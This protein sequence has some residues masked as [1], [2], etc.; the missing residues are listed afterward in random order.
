MF[1][2]GHLC[3]RSE[4]DVHTGQRDGED[5]PGGDFH[6]LTSRLQSLLQAFSSP[7]GSP[8][9]SSHRSIRFTG[10][11]RY[12]QIL[13]TECSITMVRPPG[14]RG[15]RGMTVGP[16]MALTLRT[17]SP[18]SCMKAPSARQVWPG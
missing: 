14:G 15:R 8:I 6:I 10:N 13:S 12:K 2:E 9:S 4:E 18:S 1:E 7:G 3:P 5:V 17:P 11:L 16:S